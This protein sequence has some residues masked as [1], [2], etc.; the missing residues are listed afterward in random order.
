MWINHR[1]VS[2]RHRD[3]SMILC[4]PFACN[5]LVLSL[6]RN[7]QELLSQDAL[8]RV[9]IGSLCHCPAIIFHIYS[10][11][12]RYL[13]WRFFFVIMATFQV[14]Q[15]C[16]ICFQAQY[17]F[18]VSF[19]TVCARCQSSFICVWTGQSRPAAAAEDAVSG[20][21]SLGHDWQPS[22]QRASFGAHS[23]KPLMFLFIRH[24]T[25]HLTTREQTF[26]MFILDTVD[27][28]SHVEAGA[29]FISLQPRQ[30]QNERVLKHSAAN[31]AWMTDSG[32]HTE[33][34]S[35]FVF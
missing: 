17:D 21:G 14:F 18:P 15:L 13:L 32:K 9:S 7:L 26:V 20:S 4:D 35:L 16:F 5:T 2:V 12:H 3:L 27:Q 34:K 6:I 30:K 23:L 19:P 33:A 24:V 8:P 25:V 22:F 31:K 1:R 29:R 10:Q 11:L 28:C